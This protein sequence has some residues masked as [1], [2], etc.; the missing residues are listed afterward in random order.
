MSTI[1]HS[2]IPATRPANTILSDKQL[3]RLP[4]AVMDITRGATRQLKD[5][6]ALRVQRRID[7]QAFAQLLSLDDHI[8]RDLGVT[9]ADIIW[10][11]KLP[12]DTNASGELE[13]I[14]RTNRAYF[15]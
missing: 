12:I 13:K 14:A 1:C 10:A 5:A 3:S 2:Q 11:K 9:R 8:L 7:R 15:W 6:Y 4:Q